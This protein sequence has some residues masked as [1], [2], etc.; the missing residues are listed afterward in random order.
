MVKLA[1]T[2]G[3]GPDAE[4]F[5]GSTPTLGIKDFGGGFRKKGLVPALI[6]N[7][8]RLAPTI[9]GAANPLGS[10]KLSRVPKE[11]QACPI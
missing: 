8:A 5:V 1:N 3:L 2:S 4:R 9:V 7:R 11:L 6:V 10:I